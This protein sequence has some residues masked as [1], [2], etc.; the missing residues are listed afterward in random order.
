MDSTRRIIL[1]AITWQILGVITMTALSYPHTGS[2]TIALTLSVSTSA[3]GFVSFLVHERIWNSVRWGRKA[4]EE[5][6]P[7]QHQA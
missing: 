3:A 7:E 6:R 1:K 5:N 4:A 2:L